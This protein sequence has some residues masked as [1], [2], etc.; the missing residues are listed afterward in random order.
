[1]SSP[2]SREDDYQEYYNGF[3]NRVLWP[4]LHYRLDLA[5]FARRDLS[6]YFRVND[7]FASELEKIIEPDDVIWVH[8]YHLIPIADA[9]RRRSV[10]PTALASFFTSRCRRRRCWPR[11]PITSGSSPLLLQYDVVGFQTDGDA[12]NF[13]RY[14]M[15]EAEGTGRAP[16]GVRDPRDNRIT[17]T[18]NGQRTRVGSFPVGIEPLGFQRLARRTCPFAARSRSW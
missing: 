12:A 3:A 15:A 16:Q 5:E 7:R 18:Q 4:I 9:L 6:G 8:D 13:V 17:L 10:T 2:I 11:C 14:V 1:M